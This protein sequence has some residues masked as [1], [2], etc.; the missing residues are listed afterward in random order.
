MTIDQKAAE[1]AEQAHLGQLYGDKP[2]IH[3][4]RAVVSVMTDAGIQDGDLLAAAF[5]HDV[6]EDTA[7]KLEQ[8]SQEFGLRVAELVQAVTDE[9]GK[10]RAER[11][12]KTY[13][14]VLSVEGAKT[15][16]LADRLAN[17]RSCSITGNGSL[18]KMY[19]G[20]HREFRAALYRDEDGPV[21]QLL[22]KELD[23]LLS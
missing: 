12:R 5:L 1:F 8:V 21:D 11:K 4:I 15:V 7:I 2:Y 9:P 13:P 18:L 6:I 23:S 20:E 22:W 16:K 19:I 3:H 14:K 17:V 10:N